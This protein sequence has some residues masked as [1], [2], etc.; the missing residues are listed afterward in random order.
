MTDTSLGSKSGFGTTF[1]QRSASVPKPYNGDMRWVTW[2]S[3]GDLGFGR[4]SSY[5]PQSNTMNPMLLQS[6]GYVPKECFPYCLNAPSSNSA[7]T[8]NGNLM[9]QQPAGFMY[10]GNLMAPY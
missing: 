7:Q 4:W 1:A 3:N 2:H 6:C 9:G 5:A 8:L 10:G